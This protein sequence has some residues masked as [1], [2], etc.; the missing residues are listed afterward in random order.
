MT[1]FMEALARAAEEKLP[2][3]PPRVKINN[4]HPELE[5]IVACRKITLEQDDEE[6]IKI[7]TKL[8]RRRARRIRKEQMNKFRLGMASCEVL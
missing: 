7:L 6:D 3:R 5:R 4:C 1:S 8:C 2:L